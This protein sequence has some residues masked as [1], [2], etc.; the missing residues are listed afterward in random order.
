MPLVGWASLT[1][2][3]MM[4][5]PESLLDHEFNKGSSISTPEL[6]AVKTKKVIIKSYIFTHHTSVEIISIDYKKI[7]L[8]FS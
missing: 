8:T 4:F 7:N 2:S 3:P 1:K 6:Q 5:F